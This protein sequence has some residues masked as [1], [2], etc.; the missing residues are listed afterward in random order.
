MIYC[1]NCGKAISKKD[2][3]ETREHIPAQ[4]LFAGYGE[5]F[6]KNR[7][8]VPACLKCNG[9]STS[10]DEEFRNLIGI[11]SNFDEHRT[12]SSD[13]AK[14][15]I[16]YKKQFDHLRLD[17][18][19]GV[20]AVELNEKLIL[21]NHV[22]IFKGLFY[23]QY[24]RPIPNEYRIVAMFEPTD[25]TGSAIQYLEENFKWKLSGHADVFEYI[26]QPF[27]EDLVN[28][29]NKDIVPVE[30]EP[31]YMGLLKYNKSH[32]ALVLATNQEIKQR[33]SRQ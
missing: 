31:Y 30:N 19:G 5:E 7:I 15:I 26:L 11:I 23:H 29:T 32:A 21:D 27:R 13:A 8:V 6:K 24:K 1:Y 22:K 28:P 2:G 17:F 14:S 25:F 16:T 4:N 9:N 10:V 12:I 20:R 3:T 18:A 33:R